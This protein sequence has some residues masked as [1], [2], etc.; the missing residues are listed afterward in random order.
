MCG[1]FG[2]FIT[3]GNLLDKNNF[4]NLLNL[5]K[6]RGPDFQDYFCDKKMLQLGFNRL[7][8]LDLTLVS[9]QPIRSSSGRYTMVFNGEIYN[10]L[11]LR[12]KLPKD[13]YKFKSNGDTESLIAFIDYFGIDK[14]ISLLDGMFAIAVFDH[15]SKILS[16]I[17]DFAGI[18]PL[19]YGFKNKNIVFASQ[20][21]QIV[22]HPLFRGIAINPDI[23]KLFLKQQFIPSPFGM[24]KD[25]HQVFPGEIISFDKNGKKNERKFWSLPKE[26][27]FTVRDRELAIEMVDS[28]LEDSISS[29]LVS[30]VP[31]GAFLSGGIDSS[32]VCYY[33]KI[34]SSKKFMSITAGTSSTVHDESYESEQFAKQIGLN[35]KLIHVN[36]S[37]T[38]DLIHEVMGSTKEP[39]SDSSIIPTY[40]LCK[41]A[42][43]DFTVALSGDG[44]DEIFFG[45]EKFWSIAKNFNMQYKPHAL[46][47][48]I[49]GL[50]KLFYDNAHYN[51][52]LLYDSVGKAH[53]ESNSKFPT[54][55]LNLIC[56]DLI[57]VK[58][59]NIYYLHFNNEPE[60]EL[61]L[62]NR[63]RYLEFY[64]MLQKVLKKVDFGS[65]GNSLEV[66]IPFLSKN[67]IEC[68]LKLHPNLSYGPNRRKIS[69]KKL[70]LQNLLTR[71]VGNIKNNYIKKGFSIP[72]QSWIKGKLFNTISETIL[73][74]N[75]IQDFGISS[76]N[77]EKM[78]IDHKDGKANY[79][80]PIFTLFALNHWSERLKK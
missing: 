46:K 76:K 25:T 1:I 59:P 63:I 77:V 31:L 8:I 45:Y 60:N 66:R 72:I 17:R 38:Y 11:I 51:G 68:S 61:E 69:K 47:Y 75:N 34:K 70:I 10:H 39:F 43:E 35:H 64:G 44:A 4:L 29:Q 26:L 74:K 36:E 33:S 16:L 67:I 9:M 13:K 15:K 18:K 12:K 21:D 79:R 71:K 7:S 3:N 32:L 23:L 2:E 30:D 42:K 78:L 28:E 55:I 53:F 73:D 65:M 62:L 52:A 80:G 27:N 58:M 5:S 14:A 57:N 49:Y 24:I 54:K 56:P 41:A 37:N 19:H 22:K 40:I 6:K 20:F 50:D 48:L